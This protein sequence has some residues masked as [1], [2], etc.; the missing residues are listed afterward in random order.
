M[1]CSVP[2]SSIHGIFRKGYWSRL[3]FPFPGHLPDPVIEPK[4]PLLQA[5]RSFTDW[6]TREAHKHWSSW[7]KSNNPEYISTRT[8]ASQAPLSMGF[9]R[10]EHWNGVP[11]LSSEDLPDPGIKHWSHALQT[12]S[13]PFELQ[14]S[15]FNPLLLIYSFF[16]PPLVT[17][18]LFSLSVSLFLLYK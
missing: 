8:V 11:F 17:I 10:Q 18:K 12:D 7:R 4:S 13:L 9:S 3:P 14:G 16:F 5:D 6:A 2:G 15:L 1:G